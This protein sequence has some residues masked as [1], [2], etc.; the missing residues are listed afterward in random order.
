[1]RTLNKKKFCYALSPNGKKILDLFKI[2]DDLDLEWTEPEYLKRL[3][4][5]RHT[6]EQ[7]NYEIQRWKEDKKYP[8]MCK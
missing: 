3:L 1:M 7:A 8:T 2:I 6:L 4:L 5:S